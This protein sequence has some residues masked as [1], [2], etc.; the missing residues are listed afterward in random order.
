MYDIACILSSHLKVS[1]VF[2]FW[3]TLGERV[4]YGESSTI[5]PP[6]PPPP[7]INKC[8]DSLEEEMY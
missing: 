4:G 1:F 5:S 7:S 2:G 6:P 8:P 3:T